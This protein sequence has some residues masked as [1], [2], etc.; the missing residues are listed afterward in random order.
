MWHTGVMLIRKASPSDVPEILKLITELAVYE[1]EPDA[2]KTTEAD[3]LRDGFS[4]NP[5]FQCLVAETDTGVEG[6]ALFFFRWSTWEGRPSLFLEDLYVR[7]SQRG[8]G[9]GMALLKELAKVAVENNCKRFEW[10]VLDWNQVARDFYHKI[11][12][13]HKEG[14]LP[15][16]L[17]GEPLT[18]FAKS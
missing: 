9:M 6:L 15:Y 3:L 10:E 16:R 2:V 7:D 5:Y 13:T 17:D 11:G 1:N 4:E 14:W 8:K 18:T 12:A